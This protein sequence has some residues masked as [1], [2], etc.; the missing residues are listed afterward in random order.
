MAQT[1][2]AVG[3]KDFESEDSEE[4][5]FTG[6]DLVLGT[7]NLCNH[8]EFNSVIKSGWYR[9]RL[10]LKNIIYSAAGL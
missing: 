2:E 4:K 9:K 5:L 3:K 8:L 1:G 10:E 7:T 6:Q